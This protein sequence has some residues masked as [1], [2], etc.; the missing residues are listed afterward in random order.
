MVGDPRD[1]CACARCL[2]A[3]AGAAGSPRKGRVTDATWTGARDGADASDVE[4]CVSRYLSMTDGTRRHVASEGVAAA[5]GSRPAAHRGDG[6]HGVDVRRLMSEC[7]ALGRNRLA[8][9]SRGIGL[10]KDSPALRLCMETT[11]ASLL[12]QAAY[13]R[14]EPE[15]MPS[16]RCAWP[17]CRSCI[18]RVW[19]CS[20]FCYI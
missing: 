6:G 12:W 7:D 4:E 8:R 9:C 5:A 15:G 11:R 10:G 20:M 14:P 16:L 13:V 17:S 2:G 19:G 18:A 3:S 1:D